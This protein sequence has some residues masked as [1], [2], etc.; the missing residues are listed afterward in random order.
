[1]PFH[2][3]LTLLLEGANQCIVWARVYES[4]TA[5]VEKVVKAAEEVLADDPTSQKVSDSIKDIIEPFLQK[6]QPLD[7]L[8]AWES[9]KELLADIASFPDSFWEDPDE[10]TKEHFDADTTELL[11]TMVNAVYNAF[12]IT[13]PEEE[14][15]TTQPEYQQS[16]IAMSIVRRFILIVSYF[17]L[18]PHHHLDD[19]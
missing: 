3:A 18:K 7:V 16:E 12:E 13:P 19:N 15:G 2:I 17:L 5:A 9:V 11:N 4:A 14:K 8:E 10:S 1:M 6:Y